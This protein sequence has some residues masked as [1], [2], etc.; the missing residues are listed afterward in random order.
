MSRWVQTDV[1]PET[2]AQTT[3]RITCAAARIQQHAVSQDQATLLGILLQQLADG[4]FLLVRLKLP[5][6]VKHVGT[7]AR[8]FFPNGTW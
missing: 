5:V 3:Q 6:V 7:Q 8:Q 2:H 1:A 4:R